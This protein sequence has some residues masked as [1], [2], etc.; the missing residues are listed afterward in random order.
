MTARVSDYRVTVD[1][2]TET[3][4][5]SAVVTVYGAR[6]ADIAISAANSKVRSDRRRHVM[7]I[8]GGSADEII[9]ME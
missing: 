3:G 9:P 2:Q 6:N 5:N 7:K 8:I 4:A 1:Y